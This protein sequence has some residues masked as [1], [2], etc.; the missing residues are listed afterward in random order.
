MSVLLKPQGVTNQTKAVEQY[1]HIL[2]LRLL[3]TLVVQGCC[4]VS[5]SG[6]NLESYSSSLN[7]VRYSTATCSNFQRPCI[8]CE[9]NIFEYQFFLYYI[10]SGLTAENTKPSSLSVSWD[11]VLPVKRGEQIEYLLQSQCVG[12]DQDFVQVSWIEMI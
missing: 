9:L 7:R 5:Y 8:S 3:S 11:P 2:S 12:K 1:F 6:I 10:L 4:N